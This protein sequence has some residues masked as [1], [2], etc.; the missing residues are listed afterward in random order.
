LGKLPTVINFNITYLGR[1]RVK[2]STNIKL[3]LP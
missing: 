2:T 3:V 1:N